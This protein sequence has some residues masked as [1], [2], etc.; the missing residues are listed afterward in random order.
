M[1]RFLVILAALA[2]LGAPVFAEAD[3]PDAWRVT[4]VAASDMLNVRVGPGAD[5]FVIGALPHN[6]RALQI[7]TCV[8]TV[9]RD[10][11]FALT[12]AQQALLNSYPA[13]C[14]VIVDGGQ[15]GWVNRRFLTEDGE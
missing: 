12:E 7:G 2:G 3:G 6:A 13:W 9:T 8:P 15:L 1:P 4:G 11:F 14:V 5:Y 10:Q